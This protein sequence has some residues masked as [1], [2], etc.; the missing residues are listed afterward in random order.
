MEGV[1]Y[2]IMNIWVVEK[3]RVA[4]WH[5]DM[6]VSEFGEGQA[7]DTKAFDLSSS[8]SQLVYSLGIECRYPLDGW[9]PC[10][11]HGGNLSAVVQSI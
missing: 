4:G 2:Y 5:H 11:D 8:G 6:E 7:V 9:S 10:L 3:L 1:Y